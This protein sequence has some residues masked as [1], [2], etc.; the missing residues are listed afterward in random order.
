MDEIFIGLGANQ[1]RQVLNLSRANRHGLIAGAT[2]TGK[3]VT[4][5][6]IAEQFS[7]LGVPVFVADV[8]GDLSGIS[9]AGSHQFKHAET[10]EARQK[11]SAWP[12]IPTA[13]I[14]RSTGICT[15]RPATP[16]ARRFPKWGR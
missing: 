16:S 10:L 4:L 1:E 7:A 5:Q 9:M 2:G 15:A 13:T 14:R 12:I 6:T 8:K 11:R 3:T